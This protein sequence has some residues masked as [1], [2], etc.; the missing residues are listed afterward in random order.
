MPSR[1]LSH[2]RICD[3]TGQLA[4]AGA[5]RFLAAFGAQVIRIEDPTNQG[6]WDIL[7]GMPPYKDERRGIDLGGAFNNHNVEKLGITL[8]LRTQRGKQLFR[9]LVRISDVVSENFAAGVMARLGFGYD[10]LRALRDDVIYVSNCGFGHSG[11]YASFKTWGPIVQAVCGLTFT[12]GL[13]EQPPAGWGYSYMDHTGGYYMAIAILLALVHRERTGEGQWVDM[14][15]TEAG[16][17]LLG[18]AILDYTVNGRPSRRPGQPHSNRSD[19]PPMA[20]HAIFP[21]QGDDAWVAIACRDDADW[22]ALGGVV[23]ADWCHAARFARL[24]GRLAHQDELEAALAGWTRARSARAT[25]AALVQAGVPATPV[26]RPG[27]RI[28]EDP[29]TA[30]W[31]LWPTVKHSAIGEVRVDGLPVHFSETDWEIARGG[32]CLGE[33]NDRV[34]GDLLGL[35]RA[36][37]AELRREGVI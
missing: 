3:L 7:R 13:P 24:A 8:N 2:L 31:G 11:P 22:R 20:P 18:P 12:S 19:T 23:A 14:A 5:T 4:G 36:E 28:D 37:I 29:S 15:T 21:A 16:A 34:Y 33:H 35:S 1:A 6:R 27:E 32:P 26:Q 10:A 9:E 17:T 25:A 30:A